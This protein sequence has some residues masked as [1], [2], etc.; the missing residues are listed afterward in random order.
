MDLASNIFK[1]FNGGLLADDKKPL[2]KYFR[3]KYLL[4]YKDVPK[5]QLREYLL[6]LGHLPFSWEDQFTSV[7]DIFDDVLTLMAK[8]GLSEITSNS[9]EI[10]IHEEAIY[11][12]CHAVCS[13]LKNRHPEMRHYVGFAY[14]DDSICG[15]D[16]HLHSWL[17]DGSGR[18]IEG[19]PI[20]RDVYFGVEVEPDMPFA[21]YSVKRLT[22]TGAKDG[23]QPSHSTVE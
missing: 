8:K 21:I 5:Y 19:T 4:K 3:K 22:L 12:E 20:K 6:A 11:S 7:D 13:L 14:S 9:E 10:V 1:D 23:Q 16:W 2:K 17:M 18:I 15:F